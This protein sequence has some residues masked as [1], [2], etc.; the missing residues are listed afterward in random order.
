MSGERVRTGPPWWRSGVY[1][2]DCSEYISPG[3]YVNVVDNSTPVQVDVSIPAIIGVAEYG[4]MNAPK[5]YGP[6][7]AP[8]RWWQFWRWHL[9]P[10]YR[11]ECKE[12]LK[13][14]VRDFGEPI[15]PNEFCRRVAA[16]LPE[17]FPD[18]R[19]VLCDVQPMTNPIK[20]GEACRKRHKE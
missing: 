17:P 14:L 11:R 16:S 15:S 3:V 12:A 18:I 20:G 2:V 6:S 9:I 8:I 19:H 7:I 10:R 4:P 13:A 1:E 5:F